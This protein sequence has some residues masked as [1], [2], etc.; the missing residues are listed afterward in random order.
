VT[1]VSPALDKHQILST[2]HYSGHRI[3]QVRVVFQIPNNKIDMVFPSPDTRPPSYLAYVEWFTPIPAEPEPK[4]RMYKVSRSIQNGQRNAVIIPVE[5]IL[6]SIHLLPRFTPAGPQ[7]W[8][9][10][11]VLEKCHTF[12]INPFTDMYCYVTFG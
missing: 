5:S 7:G 1:K 11:T 9:T 12:Y 6:C 8:N 3:A 4:H 10:F 2:D